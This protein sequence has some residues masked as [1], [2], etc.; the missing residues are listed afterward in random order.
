MEDHGPPGCGQ[1]WE[2]GREAAVPD[3]VAGRREDDVGL[4]GGPVGYEEGWENIVEIE[5]EVE[6]GMG[7]FG[8]GGDG[9]VGV[10]NVFGHQG[11]ERDVEEDGYDGCE[12]AGGDSAEEG[13]EA[14]LT[15]EVS[16]GFAEAG[17]CGMNIGGAGRENG[18][19]VAVVGAFFP[20]VKG[21]LRGF[22]NG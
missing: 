4:G 22:A 2:E 11:V 8:R 20:A 3:A 18:G 16:E 12:D 21:G 1:G 17:G 9:R 19:V 5:E 13:G 7:F 6:V 15:E 14:G 10:R